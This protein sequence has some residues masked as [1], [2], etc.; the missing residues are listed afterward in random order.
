MSGCWTDVPYD[1][2]ANNGETDAPPA[3][4]EVV[5]PLAD[6]DVEL[7][8]PDEP[9]TPPADETPA[10]E[11]TAET[12]A[13]ADSSELPMEQPLS[14][15]GAEELFPEDAPSS[16]PAAAD[17]EEVDAFLSFLGPSSSDT[18]PTEEE[19]PAEPP[20]TEATKPATRQP[21]S[22]IGGIPPKELPPIEIPPLENPEPQTSGVTLP[23]LLPGD[24]ATLTESTDKQPTEPKVTPP[25]PTE[26]V[27]AEPVNPEPADIAVVE[28]EP[29]EPVPSEPVEELP[30][31]RTAGIDWLPRTTL[32]STP[33]S[34]KPVSLD[35]RQLT[36][37]FASRL[38]YLLVA[39]DTD[40]SSAEQE[41]QPVASLLGVEMPSLPPATDDE[42]TRLKQ[43]LATGRELGTSIQAKYGAEHA[44]LVEV[45]FKS[46]LM[47][48]VAE[49]RP[50]LKHNINAAVSAAAVR[51][52]LPDTLWEPYQTRVAESGTADEISNAVLDLQKQVG[53][54]LR[55]SAASAADD[56]PPVLR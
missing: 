22:P 15:G 5:V 46:N 18:K 21:A 54:Y 17:E 37:M 50:Q 45:A 16:S 52:A 55:Q 27:P 23:W 32:P 29:T 4:T 33:V 11:T 14:S 56:E 53:N 9:E 43:L 28:P 6:P 24:S 10:V 35:S 47:L 40:L 7:F 1:S 41:L 42:G 48:A 19:P 36:W 2:Q 3:D 30:E 34:R 51:A 26:T 31:P 8:A 25:A 39:P 49:T 38:S 12:P 44:A 13:A 20:A